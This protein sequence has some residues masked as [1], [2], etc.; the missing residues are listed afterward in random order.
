[1]EGS[2]PEA[3]ELVRMKVQSWGPA[4]VWA[5]WRI[6]TAEETV[7]DQVAWAYERGEAM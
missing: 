3:N 2:K 6:P 1:M 7:L 5:G 4:C